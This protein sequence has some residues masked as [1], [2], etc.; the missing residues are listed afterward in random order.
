[1]LFQL[2]Y[3]FLEFIE[4]MPGETEQDFYMYWSWGRVKNDKERRVRLS[5]KSIQPVISTIHRLERKKLSEGLYLKCKYPNAALGEAVCLNKDDFKELVNM[6]D[7]KEDKKELINLFGFSASELNLFKNHWFV[8][9]LEDD[10]EFFEHS[11]EDEEEDY[12]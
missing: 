7:D 5:R 3:P 4:K 1:M 2:S 10:G 6:I 12:E 8:L 9:Y 11:R